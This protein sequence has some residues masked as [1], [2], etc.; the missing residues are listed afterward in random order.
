M[1]HCHDCGLDWRGHSV[2]HCS[3][4]CET[5]T[6]L[7]AFDAHQTRVDGRL[8]CLPPGEVMRKDGVT[9]VLEL[10]ANGRWGLVGSWVPFDPSH[11]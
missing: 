11:V 9:P 4:C 3:G 7:S 6:S 5:F 1:A 2:C 8:R 10:K